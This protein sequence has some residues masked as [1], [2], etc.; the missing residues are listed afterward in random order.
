MMASPIIFIHGFLGGHIVNSNSLDY[1]DIYDLSKLASFNPDQWTLQEDYRFDRLDSVMVEKNKFVADFMVIGDVYRHFYS[2]LKK[3]FGDQIYLFSYDWRKPCDYN[4]GLLSG[5]VNNLKI[6]LAPSLGGNIK[7]NFITHSMGGNVFLFYLKKLFDEGGLSVL[8]R[9]VI[10]ACPFRGAFIAIQ[11]LIIGAGIPLNIF[12]FNN[13]FR[14][15]ART[16]PALYELVPYNNGAVVWSGTDSNVDLLESGNWQSN[17]FT[18]TDTNGLTDNA[19]LIKKRILAMAGYRNDLFDLD[20]LPADVKENI[21]ILAGTGK[22]TV[23]KVEVINSRNGINN[24]MNFDGAVKDNN[25]DGTVHTDSSLIYKTAIRSFRVNNVDH[26]KF[27]ADG[28]TQDI[29]YRF[30]SGKDKIPAY[31]DNWW[32]L[33]N[34][35]VKAVNI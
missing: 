15:I 4:A 6:K 13:K 25:G 22:E 9:S 19:D 2:V 1:D 23:K 7:F 28:N 16:L 33:L 18:N 10:G 31:A 11:A 14:H 26:A 32:K 20:K 3:D 8:D 30:L 34:D 12:N 5:Y 24:Y 35:S 17:L 29:V 21:I 27:Y